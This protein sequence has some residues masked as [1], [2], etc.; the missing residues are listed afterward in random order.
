MDTDTDITTYSHRLCTESSEGIYMDLEFG[1]EGLRS[2]RLAKMTDGPQ[3]CMCASMCMVQLWENS[4]VGGV[5]AERGTNRDSNNMFGGQDFGQ[6][7]A[8]DK[9]LGRSGRRNGSGFRGRPR[10]SS[11][12][13]D[14]GSHAGRT[15]YVHVATWDGVLRLSGGSFLIWKA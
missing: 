2:V 13:T 1:G 11:H 5:G 15:M 4:P 6:S 8:L 14:L 3:G 12:L 9:G 10:C 7:R